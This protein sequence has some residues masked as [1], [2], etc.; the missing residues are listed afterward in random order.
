MEPV[1]YRCRGDFVLFRHVDLGTHRGLAMPN[2][3]QQGKENVVVAIGPKV[4]NLEVGDK[5]LV[6]GTLGVDSVRVPT[7]QNL[8]MTRETN[9]A[10]VRVENDKPDTTGM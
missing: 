10:L 2:V 7:E 1:K 5:V 8:Y 3:A 4:E 6:I 9:V